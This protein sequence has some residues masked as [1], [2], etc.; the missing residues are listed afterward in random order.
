MYVSSPAAP[1]S[2]CKPQEDLSITL[3]WKVIS[4]QPAP[5]RCVSQEGGLSL[6]TGFNL[7]SGAQNSISAD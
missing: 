2:G 3:S 1:F 5:L 7:L 6:P 4:G